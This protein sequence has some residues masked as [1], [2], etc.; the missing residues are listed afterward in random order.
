MTLKTL[1]RWWMRCI[2]VDCF[3]RRKKSTGR[4]SV[5]GQDVDNTQA[6]F[7]GALRKSDEVQHDDRE[8][9]VSESEDTVS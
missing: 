6:L 3:E 8:K 7:L 1:H 5:R 2:K 9:S 4:Y